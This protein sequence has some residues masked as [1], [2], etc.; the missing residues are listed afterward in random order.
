ML[1]IIFLLISREWLR[2]FKEPSRLLGMIL[3]PLLFLLLFGAGFEQIKVNYLSYFYPGI[4][5]LVVLFSSIY[6]TL[7]LVDDKNTGFFSY[8]ALGPCGLRGAI[9]GKLLATFSV[10]FLQSILFLVL[11]FFLDL[12]KS[13]INFLRLIFSLALGS[14]VF[15]TLG[16][17]FALAVSSSS[18]FHALMSVILMPMWLLSG[19]MF[20][21]LNSAFCF[22]LYINPMSFFVSILQQNIF[23]AKENQ[24]LLYLA[25]LFCLLIFQML[26][27]IL[28][29]IKRDK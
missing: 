29:K 21:L 7:S 3:Q 2:L 11:I 4:L 9:L 13:H 10:A 17:L 20:P 5:A 18:A 25:L 23:G 16:V 22:L 24:I 19:A 8:V 15:S 12:E 27:W 6:S 1:N 28:L 14:L 26:L